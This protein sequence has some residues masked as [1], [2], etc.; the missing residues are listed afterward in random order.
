M[1]RLKLYIAAYTSACTGPA[2][3]HQHW[4]AVLCILGHP[5]QFG[6]LAESRGMMLLSLPSAF[7]CHTQGLLL[8]P[9]LLHCHRRSVTMRACLYHAGICALLAWSDFGSQQ[10]LRPQPQQQQSW[11]QQQHTWDSSSKR[12][13]SAFKGTGWACLCMALLYLYTGMSGLSEY[14]L[15]TNPGE[16]FKMVDIA[17]KHKVWE[18]WGYGGLTMR[19]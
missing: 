17:Q 3:N 10:G 1:Q 8:G 6:P 12:S 5:G 16:A 11:Q 19:Q 13:S 14:K 4:P 15:P 9:S 7:P 18:Y 2:T